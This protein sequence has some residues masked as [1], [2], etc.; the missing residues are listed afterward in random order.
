M[1]VERVA[2]EA[3]LFHVWMRVFASFVQQ[4]SRPALEHGRLLKIDRVFLRVVDDWLQSFSS[5]S[6]VTSV[7]GIG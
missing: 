3:A 1:R 6:V 5:L 4:K 7:I 2:E